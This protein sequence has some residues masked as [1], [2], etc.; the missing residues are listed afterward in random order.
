MDRR[1]PRESH[2]QLTENRFAQPVNKLAAPYY[3]L[4]V[5]L[6]QSK[7][8][9]AADAQKQSTGYHK[10]GIARLAVQHLLP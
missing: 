4:K 5:K 7:S 3:D 8:W 6:R 10:E 9:L 1:Q 2:W